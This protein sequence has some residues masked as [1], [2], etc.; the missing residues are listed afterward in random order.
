[1]FFSEN[2]LSLELLGVYKLKR[3]VSKHRSY[4][5]RSYD[6]ISIRLN[7]MGNFETKNK[8]FSVK[9]G[10]ILY[11]PKNCEYTQHTSGET[12]ISIHFINY[13]FNT[14]NEIEVMTLES[15]EYT[16]EIIQNMYNIWKEKKPGHRYKCISL[17]YELLY[18]IYKGNYDQKI[19]NISNN[20]SLKIATDYIHSN[21]RSKNFE[22][23]ELAD[24]CSVSETYFRKLFKKIYAVSPKQYILNLK[25]EYASQLL[26]S[27][28][29]NVNEV[30]EKSGFADVKYF[31]R[32]FKTKFG[33]TPK[34]YQNLPHENLLK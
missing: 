24:M 16:E 20:T 4:N 14:Q 3:K 26:Q 18:Y 10:D 25:L 2:E 33:Y 6:S 9:R 13:T 32:L 30:S 7:G 27:K 34:V 11:L 19:I 12:I 17:L 1:M 5:N 31:S 29:Y 21:F 8:T 23:G 22:V 28:L 15:A